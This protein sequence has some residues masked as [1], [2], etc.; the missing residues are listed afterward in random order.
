M[1]KIPPMEWLL[2]LTKVTLIYLSR[3]METDLIQEKQ[4]KDNLTSKLR[5]IMNHTINITK[6]IKYSRF[7]LTSSCHLRMFPLCKRR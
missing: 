5:P 4:E 3:T 7:H 1:K 6:F 2:I